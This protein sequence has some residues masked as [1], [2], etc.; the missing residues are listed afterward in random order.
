M[1]YTLMQA[2][3]FAI[4]IAIPVSCAP[5]DVPVEEFPE[6]PREPDLDTSDSG[7]AWRCEGEPGDQDCPAASCDAVEERGSGT[8]WIQPSPR[9]EPFEAYCLCDVA[10]A[11]WQLVSSRTRDGGA[12]FGN[13][14]CTNTDG[15]CSGTI[16]ASQVLPGRRI[17]LLFW[18][19]D[20]HGSWLVV[21]VVWPADADGLFDVIRGKRRLGESFSCEYPHFCGPAAAIEPEMQISAH[22]DDFTPRS[23]TC[24][25]LWLEG[26]GIYCGGGGNA[27]LHVFSFNIAPYCGAGGMD[28]SSDTDDSFGDVACG[29][30]GG[31][32][33]RYL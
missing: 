18:V 22:S 29:A 11:C 33:F 16:P 7:G 30:P 24:V 13:T 14:V 1:R 8:Y 9:A 26:G 19:H 28:F 2:V 3:I 20:E 23:S 4:F 21:S 15:D 32:Y 6:T 10:D 31:I 5:P 25:Y 27:N 12:L 17:A